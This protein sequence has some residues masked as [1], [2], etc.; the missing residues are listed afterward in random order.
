MRIAFVY[1][2]V[3]PWIKGGAEKRIYEIGRR[4]A[5]RGHEVHWFG[6]KWWDG[7]KTIEQDGVLLHGVCEPMPLYVDGRRSIKEAVYFATRLFP[8][9]M[10]YRFDVIDCQQFPYFPCFV[11]K[12]QSLLKK[13]NFFITWHEV[14]GNYWYEYLGFKG[15]F[16]KLIER[17]TANITDRIIAVSEKTKKDLEDLGVKDICVVPNGIDFRKIESIDALDKDSDVIFVG[18]LIREKNVDILIKA[19]RLIKEEIPDIK[20]VIVGDGPEKE[21]LMKLSQDLGVDSNIEFTGFLKR[22]EDVIAYM[23]S[24]K[25][26]VLPSTREGFG[27]VALEANA[28]G[29]PVITVKHEKNA[30]ADLVKD[31]GGYVCELGEKD[32]AEKIILGLEKGKFMKQKCLEN[33]R[34]YDWDRIVD[35]AELFYEGKTMK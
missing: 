33:A 1:D 32:I 13:S 31:G 28:C 2:A 3:Y 24:S 8:E 17:F 34:K 27:I 4:L 7:K 26:F 9:L 21:K 30:A 20:C 14:W 25:I 15:L 10:K 19:V 16:G 22:Y 18:R 12:I 29:L 23:K 5:D 35:M 11:S 6:V